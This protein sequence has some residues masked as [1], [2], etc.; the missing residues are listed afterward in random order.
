[1]E[2]WTNQSANLHPQLRSVLAWYQAGDYAACV[3]REN[4][5]NRVKSVDKAAGIIVPKKSL[6]GRKLVQVPGTIRCQHGRV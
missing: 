6:M 4:E 5:K 2:L 1:M 3:T